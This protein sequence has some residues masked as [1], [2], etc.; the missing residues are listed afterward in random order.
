MEFPALQ[1]SGIF[2]VLSEVGKRIFLPQGIF[3]WSGRAK[4][5]ADINATIGAAE[6]RLSHLVETDE[7]RNVTFHL[8]S[9]ARMFGAMDPNEVFAYAKVLGIPAFRNGWKNYLL[10]KAGARAAK[11]KDLITAPAV[12]PGVTGGLHFVIRLF[13]DPDQKLVCPEMRWG[14]YDNIVTRNF[15]GTIR[16]YTLFTASGDPDLDSMEGALKDE[17]AASGKAV[18][19][20][21]FP[22]N[23][24]GYMPTLAQAAAIRERLVKV[25][26]E[27]G[28]PLV[29]V[30]DDAYE[31]Y[32]YEEGLLDGSLFYDLVG[33]HP[34]ILPVKLDGI[35]KEMLWYGGRVG[36]MTFGLHPDHFRSASRADVEKELMD[37]VGGI[38]RSTVSNC[39]HPVQV[40]IARVLQDIPALVAERDMTVQVLNR[41]CAAMKDEIR[42]KDDPTLLKWLP[43]QGGFFAFALCAKPREMAEHLL[44]KYRVGIIPVEN[45]QVSGIRVAFCSVEEEDM[46]RLIDSLYDAARDIREGIA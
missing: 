33:L 43:F 34:R 15:G 29:V 32:V 22:N 6:G 12:T 41:R 27:T 3:Y 39:T 38:I 14:N 40:I 44:K 2:D 19:L 26:E 8:P 28:K 25:A 13:V 4:E 1:S 24:T 7:D 46:P 16:N 36:C 18:I 45:A 30:C 5:E 17:I 37:K 11:I 42:R 31:G 9:F 21:N 23:P 10:H 20:L 35:T